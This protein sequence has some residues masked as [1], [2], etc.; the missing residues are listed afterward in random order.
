M[1]PGEYIGD[2][3]L[4]HLESLGINPN[5]HDFSS[6]NGYEGENL[7]TKT[8]FLIEVPM[9]GLPALVGVNTWENASVGHAVYWDG[10]QVFDPNCSE[11]KKDFSGYSIRHW[12]PVRKTV[13]PAEGWSQ[14]MVKRKRAADF[15]RREK[16]L[17]LE[18][19]RIDV[20]EPVKIKII[21][22]CLVRSE[23]IGKMIPTVVGEEVLVSAKDGL[24]LIQT[25]Q[26]VEVNDEEV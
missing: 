23:K 19:E 18:Q 16:L 7:A 12:I 5:E 22:A 13:D 3:I 26:A 14:L 2:L 1:K 6:E 11:P 4:K 24:G 8:S 10:H 25:G 9:E 17:R 21:R 20:A 15:K